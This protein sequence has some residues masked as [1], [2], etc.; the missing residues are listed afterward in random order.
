MASGR[1][2]T[3]TEFGAERGKCETSPAAVKEECW[4]KEKALARDCNPN[5]LRLS[6]LSPPRKASGLKMHSHEGA[7]AGQ[8][9][10]KK[11][12]RKLLKQPEASK[13]SGSRN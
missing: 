9:R 12:R 8:L 10:R 1:N 3:P 7:H 6:Q 11:V 4:R 2:N 13:N 5:R